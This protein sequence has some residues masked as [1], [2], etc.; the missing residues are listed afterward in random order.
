[1]RA[2][3]REAGLTLPS[4]LMAAA[5]YATRTR[6]EGERLTLGTVWNA[7]PEAL[8]MI[9][10]FTLGFWFDVEDAGSASLIQ[11]AAQLQTRMSSTL[12]HAPTYPMADYAGTHAAGVPRAVWSRM[13]EVDV[14][15]NYLAFEDVA[16][17]LGDVTASFGEPGARQSHW[18]LVLG[19]DP[20]PQALRLGW[21]YR[22]DLFTAAEVEV[23]A[24]RLRALLT[25]PLRPVREADV[26]FPPTGASG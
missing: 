20:L 24:H 19:V 7:Q 23:F 21:S 17:Q 8:R 2:R 15:V 3:A 4:V 14:W 25:H 1:M 5:A 16:L 22:T 12:R 11:A 10:C 6:W 26:A 9:G 18:T 13:R